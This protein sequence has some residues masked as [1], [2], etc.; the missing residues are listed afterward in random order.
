MMDAKKPPQGQGKTSGKTKKRAGRAWARVGILLALL[1]AAG[2]LLWQ[3]GGGIRPEPTGR[4]AAETGTPEPQPTPV[5]TEGRTAR[6]EAYDKDVETLR[7]LVGNER[8]DED[9]RAQAAERLTRMVADHQSELGI[10][11]ALNQAGFDPCLVLIQNGALT[12]M[13]NATELTGTESVTILSI[14]VA[15]SDI[16]VENIRIMTGGGA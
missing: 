7:E 14:C 6:E 12:V 16:G 10:E 13:V 8:A 4:P 11:E 5:P 9:T 15:H 1:L 2:M 3:N